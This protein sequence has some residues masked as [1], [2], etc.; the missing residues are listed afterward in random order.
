[1]NMSVDPMRFQ[2]RPSIRPNAVVDW[3]AWNMYTQTILITWN[4]LPNHPPTQSRTWTICLLRQSWVLIEGLLFIPEISRLT[5]C[6]SIVGQ[7]GV[8][9]AVPWYKSFNHTTILID[10]ATK[11]KPVAPPLPTEYP[12]TTIHFPPPAPGT[13]TKIGPQR[14][15]KVTQK[16]KLLP[17]DK[18]TATVTGDR[19][20]V[21]QRDIERLFASKERI[22]RFLPRV[23]AYC[24]A[25][26]YR[27]EGL[28]KF[29][30]SRATMRS[31]AP[32]LFDEW[33]CF[34]A[35]GRLM[36]VYIHR[37]RILAS[38]LHRRHLIWSTWSPSRQFEIR[39][40]APAQL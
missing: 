12:P 38:M 8:V 34:W 28:M 33:Y 1:M 40:K 10:M 7:I 13:S 22:A 31:A 30:Q 27:M 24:T 20:P 9:S 36:L 39:R 15:T 3:R 18:P 32:Q 17:E 35:L 4:G 11:K 26:S 21:A 2:L 23:T 16:L 25:S 29:L 37:I 5:R 14:T 19:D 6:V